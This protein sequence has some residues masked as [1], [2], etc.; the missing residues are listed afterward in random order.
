MGSMRWRRRR[1]R[2]RGLDGAAKEAMLTYPL[3]ERFSRKRGDR[4]VVIIL[5]NFPGEEDEHCVYVRPPLEYL[6]T[7]T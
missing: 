1:R 3:L 5:A 6:K 7:G 2:V 4:F